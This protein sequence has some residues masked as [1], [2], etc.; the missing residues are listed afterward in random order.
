MFHG[1]DFCRLGEILKDY[2]KE[3]IKQRPVNIIN[4]S[5]RYFAQF[6]R[7]GEGMEQGSCIYI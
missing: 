6:V 4:F 1:S 7:N 5:A 3:V 2:A